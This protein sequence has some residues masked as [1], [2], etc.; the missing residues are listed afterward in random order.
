MRDPISHQHPARASAAIAPSLLRL[1]VMQR[2][3][4]AVAMAAI[5]WAAVLW[6]L[7]EVAQ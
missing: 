5:L 2:I 7:T 6:A 3:S 4:I 1:S